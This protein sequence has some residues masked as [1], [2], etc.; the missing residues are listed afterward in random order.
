[1]TGFH[2]FDNE[3]TVKKKLGRPVKQTRNRSVKDTLMQ[4]YLNGDG[5][6]EVIETYG[7]C[8]RWKPKSDKCPSK[9]Y[10]DVLGNGLCMHCWDKTI[11]HKH[12]A[13]Q[14]LG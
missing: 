11:D 14:Q 10:P 3:R 5:G 1:M 9:G 8:I 12:S 4:F 6:E 13:R 7:T 2:Q